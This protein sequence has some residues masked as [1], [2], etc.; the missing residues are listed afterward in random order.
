VFHSTGLNAAVELIRIFR[1][2]GQKGGEV[3]ME[4]SSEPNGV[5]GN[6]LDRRENKKKGGQRVIL[7]ARHHN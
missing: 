2:H 6:A 5:I 7:D 4:G 1:N 3:A